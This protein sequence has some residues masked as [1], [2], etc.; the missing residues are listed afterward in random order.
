MLSVRVRSL[1]Q[2]QKRAVTMMSRPPSLPQSE[3]R[4]A[5]TIMSLRLPL[6]CRGRRQKPLALA[7]QAVTPPRTTP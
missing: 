1:A 2:S 3:E 4:K 6:R 5:N 7:S